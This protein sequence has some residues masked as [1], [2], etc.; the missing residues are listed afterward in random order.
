MK[1]RD[2]G[3]LN[4]SVIGLLVIIQVLFN[5][6]CTEKPSGHVLSN[7]EDDTVFNIYVKETEIGT[8]V[9]SIDL[10]G[11]YHRKI[12]IA[13][14]GQQVDM[15]MDIKPDQYGDWKTI[16]INNPIFGFIHAGRTGNKAKF[17]IKGKKRTAELPEKD[18]TF[19]D[20][21]GNLFESVML[22]KYDMGKKGKQVFKR[23]RIPET[24]GLSE[25]IL[26]I[27]LEFLEQRKKIIKNKEWEFLI[28]KSWE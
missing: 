18:Y 2:G 22:K 4:S 27:E 7:I 25:T 12:T 23:F 15:T 6:N 8:I 3:Y 5:V 17:F 1:L 9:N 20:D 16:E 10:Q 19:Y 13:M 26:E 28:T 11:N 24:P 21:Y 14:A